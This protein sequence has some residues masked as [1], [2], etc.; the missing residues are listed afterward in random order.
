V[1]TLGISIAGYR[2][3][4]PSLG[5]LLGIPRPPRACGGE[6]RWWRWTGPGFTSALSGRRQGP[7]RFL[8]SVPDL[9][10]G[11]ALR[12]RV[13]S[14]SSPRHPW[15]SR[16]AMPA[17]SDASTPTSSRR[18]RRGPCW[19]SIRRERRG[20]RSSPQ[21][22]G[23]RQ[24]HPSPHT[25]S[26]ASSAAFRSAAVLGFVGAGGIG[27]EINLSMRLFEYGQ[28][29]TLLAAFVILVLCVDAVSRGAFADASGANAVHGSGVLRDVVELRPVRAGS[30]APLGP[31]AGRRVRASG[32]R[33]PLRAGGAP[34]PG[35]FRRAALSAGPVGGVP[36]LHLLGPSGNGGHP[37]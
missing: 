5:L 23:R 32:I 3:S 29:T 14:G 33:S 36:R 6:A 35:R 34:A 20:S 31:A 8:R 22:S 15:P 26:T 11:A 18:S 17:S 2:A 19:P 28:V 13:R 27:A 16:S 9:V 30:A 4:P 37:R 7:A 10:L 12:G 25:R 21:P 24:P 1:R